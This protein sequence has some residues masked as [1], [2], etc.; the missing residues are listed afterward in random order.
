[1]KQDYFFESGDTAYRIQPGEAVPAIET[2]TVVRLPGRSQRLEVVVF[3]RTN[4]DDDERPVDGVCLALDDT[5]HPSITLA[6]NEHLDTL[7]AKY[8]KERA[9]LQSLLPSLADKP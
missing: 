9:E 4:A 3:N 2:G 8:A 5:W 1:M 7:T 6:V